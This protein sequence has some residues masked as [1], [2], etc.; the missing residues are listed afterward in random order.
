MSRLSFYIVDVF[1]Q[2]KY[3]GNPLAV[4]LGA[5]SL[6]P[7]T[8]QQIAREINFSETT[9]VT[10]PTPQNGGYDVRI[11]TPLQELPFAGHPTLGTAYVLQQALVQKPVDQV[12]L[13]LPVGQIPV[14]L[15]YDDGVPSLLWMQQKLP[16]FHETWSRATLAP[17]LGLGEMALDSCF[18]IQ[19]VS[20]GVPVIIVPLT[21]PQALQDVHLDR[22]RYL[23][24]IETTTAKMILVFCPNPRGSDRDLRVRVFAEA[25]GVPEDPATGSAN[26]CLAAYL[27]HHNYWGQTAINIRVEQGAELGRP[28]LL[29]LKARK[30]ETGIAVAVG[31]QVMMVAQGQWF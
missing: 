9:F 19:T 26:G 13:N 28:S 17:T 30:E 27:V 7:Q 25:L 8:M 21:S 15:H 4:V 20:T 6:S 14:T 16:T 11:F 3:T 31:G 23:K 5:Q 24:L 1:A 2:E 29:L 18:P 22:D 10:S 12:I